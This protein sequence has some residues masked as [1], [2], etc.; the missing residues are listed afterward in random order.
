MNKQGK[1]LVISGFSGAGKGTV[2]K[3]MLEDVARKYEE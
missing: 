1:L 3:K 2:M